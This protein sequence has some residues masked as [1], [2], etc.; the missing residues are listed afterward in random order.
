MSLE[1]VKSYFRKYDMED[2]IIIV[3]GSSATVSK[4]AEALGTQ[5][6]RIAKT[7]AFV[8][9]DNDFLVVMAG[10]AKVDN[11]KF[12]NN[13]KLKAKMMDADGVLEKTG[14]PVGGVCP[15]AL[16]DKS[17][18]VYLDQSLKRFETVF[19][20]CGSLDSAIELDLSELQVHSQFESWVDV[21]KDN[22][23]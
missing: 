3:H 2:R 9:K 11:K 15:F 6:E 5:E 21:A 10:D 13:F 23:E 1:S 12:K 19:P 22:D 4:A 20:A 14:H 16:N 17:L 18:V 8:G 7:L